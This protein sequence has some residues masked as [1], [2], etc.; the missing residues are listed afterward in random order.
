MS[1]SPNSSYTAHPFEQGIT[2]DAA[3]SR[4]WEL[5]GGK[6]TSIR[7]AIDGDAPDPMLRAGLQTH[8]EGLCAFG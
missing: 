4:G 5:T 3:T 6:P 8:S 7:I 1:G 2:H